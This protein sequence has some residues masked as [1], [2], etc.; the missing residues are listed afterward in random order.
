MFSRFLY[1]YGEMSKLPTSR[2]PVTPSKIATAAK[3]GIRPPQQ[4]TAPPPA[5]QISPNS[6]DSS[7]EP[8]KINDRVIANGNKHGM[9]AYIGPT[10]FADGMIFM[11]AI[12]SF[13]TS[14]F[15]TRG[16]D[17]NHSR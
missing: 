5:Q 13:L 14:I 1:V 12:F 11:F 10:K 8:L 7:T 6:G 17:R 16:M 2:L 4:T 9:V 15:N 3:T